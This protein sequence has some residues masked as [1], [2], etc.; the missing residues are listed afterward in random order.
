MSGRVSDLQKDLQLK[1]EKVVHDDDDENDGRY[2][3]RRITW[4]QNS[5]FLLRISGVRMKKK[6]VTFSSESV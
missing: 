3:A 5:S 1:K 2:I 4:T 6:K